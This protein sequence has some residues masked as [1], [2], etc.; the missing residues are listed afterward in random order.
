[1]SIDSAVILHAL[2]S[3]LT[4]IIIGGIGYFLAKRGWF[5]EE[6]NALM[7]K[8]VML[9]ALPPYLLYNVTSVLTLDDLFKMG[10][11]LIAPFTSML[12][13]T[14]LSLLTAK[15]IHVPRTRR[16]VFCSSFS[17]SNSVL[18]GIPVNLALFGE[19]SLPYTLLYYFANT[20]LFWSIGNYLLA[21]D[22]DKSKPKIF[23]MDTARKVLSPPLLGFLIGLVMLFLG[24]KLPPFLASTAR[25]L[26][27]LTTPLVMISIGVTLYH[28]GINRIRPSLELFFVALSR[29]VL[30]PFLIILVTW[31]VPIPDLMRKV[32]IIQASLPAMAS[33]AM[34][35]HYYETD[36]DYATV[37][38]S[39]T[40]L[41]SIVTIPFYMVLSTWLS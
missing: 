23:S 37:M 35:T 40:T 5:T 24:V 32:F 3:I 31:F 7:S 1:M 21:S 15:A 29:F 17:F 8:L 41:L 39:A 27:G 19:K 2:E 11:G 6:S 9:V 4:F 13:A 20:T 30:S 38:V 36:V 28:M 14:G 12:L 22:S 10:H 18:I 25:H 34:L 26:G 16:G 33:I